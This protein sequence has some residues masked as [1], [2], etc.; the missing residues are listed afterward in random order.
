M[1]QSDPPELFIGPLSEGVLPSTGVT[2]SSIPVTFE[3]VASGDHRTRG[4]A[5]DPVERKIF[6]AE[7]NAGVVKW[8]SLDSP[9]VQ[10]TIDATSNSTSIDF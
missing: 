2:V 1:N 4:L 7:R 8:A 3:T 5:Y 10:E 6:W 9:S